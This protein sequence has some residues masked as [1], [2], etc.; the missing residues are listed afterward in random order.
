MQQRVR[1]GKT[2]TFATTIARYYSV[3]WRW[4]W[5]IVQ[6]TLRSLIQ[7]A[8]NFK[9]N[10]YSLC[11]FV[12]MY[13]RWYAMCVCICKYASILHKLTIS[14]RIIHI[15]NWTELNTSRPT[16]QPTIQRIRTVQP[17]RPHKLPLQNKKTT[18]ANANG[19]GSGTSLLLSNATLQ[20]WELFV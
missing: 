5:R 16:I 19:L 1:R 13:S 2:L 18:H 6:T 7:Q 10:N 8:Q 17:N 12:W 4:R 20:P 9:V 3:W 15:W 11:R 14:E